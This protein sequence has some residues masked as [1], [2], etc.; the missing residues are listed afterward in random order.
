MENPGNP[1]LHST[2]LHFS[3]IKIPD[4]S[5]N[6][7]FASSLPQKRLFLII[8]IIKHTPLCEFYEPFP[9]LCVL[10]LLEEWNKYDEP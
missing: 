9:S 10:E 8:I 5:Y 1:Q 4:F 2:P 3:C 6:N 7:I